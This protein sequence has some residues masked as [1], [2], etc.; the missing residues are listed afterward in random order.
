[1]G[2]FT[3]PAIF[4]VIIICILS[5]FVTMDAAKR[6][7]LSERDEVDLQKVERHPVLFNPIILIYVIVGLFMGIII[8]YYW[9]KS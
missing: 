6:S 7:Q 3:Y 2:I 4:V 8:F 9:A 1:M 5:A